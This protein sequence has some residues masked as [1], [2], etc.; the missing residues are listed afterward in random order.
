MSASASQRANGVVIPWDSETI[1]VLRNFLEERSEAARIRLYLLQSQRCV[2]AAAICTAAEELRTARTWLHQL[3]D[4]GQLV[5]HI[6]NSL[7]QGE[8]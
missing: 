3:V 4:S 7:S 2:N 1:G 6:I 5:Q 8:G